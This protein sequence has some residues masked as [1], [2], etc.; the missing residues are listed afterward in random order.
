MSRA[1]APRLAIPAALFASCA[2]FAQTASHKP[3]TVWTDGYESPA[4][5]PRRDSDA[6]RFLAQATFGPT[7]A[8][9]ARLRTLGYRAWLDQQFNEPVSTSEPYLD[10]VG[11]IPDND[12]TDDTRLEIWAI[13]AA[14]LPD[15]SRGQQ[16]PTDL[17]R[18]RVAFALSQIFV[19]SNANGTLNY[20]PWAL[21]SYQDMLATRAFGNFSDLLKAVTLHPA[22]GIYLNMLQNQK[23]DDEQNIHPD[24]NF[25]REVL[26]LFSVGLVRLNED[27]TP[28][29]V[30]GQLVPTYNQA[31][32]R[33]F[34]AVFTG[35]NWSN[36]GC[37]ANTYTCCDEETYFWCGPGNR[38]EAPWQQPMQPVEAYHDT[39]TDKQLLNYATVS[40]P[41][42]VLPH[43]G[44]ATAELDAALANIVNHPNVGPFIARR[45]IQNLVTSNPSPAY[46]R[47][48]A[49]AFANN[50]QGV[51]GD[52]KA[53]LRAVLLDAEARSGHLQRPETFGKLREP[54]LKLTHMWRAMDARAGNGRVGNLSTWPPLELRLG[55]APL[56]SPTVF[57]FFKP[58]YS[59][60]GEVRTAGMRAPEFQILSDSLAVSTP[61]RLFYEL[62]CFY[63]GSDRCWD[64]DFADTLQMNLA[65]D[66]P[67][68]AS[69]PGALLDRYNLLFLSGQMSPFMRATILTQLQQ[70]TADDY[71]SALGRVRVQN[72]LY[73]ILN[74]PEYSVQK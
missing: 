47:R 15:P 26:Q 55:E 30:N 11:N 7:T 68:A 20:Q 49:A 12:V 9:I 71:G 56:R 25:A 22:M 36:V 27:G 37:G 57:N 39:T 65:R 18:Q 17:L 70:L 51:R 64:S 16:V 53:V 40:L 29:L 62:F 54:L 61:N 34:A 48:V 3:D 8:E 72:A 44:N 52:M 67:L 45:L 69:N 35:W 60:P 38:D 21:A 10:W 33:G 6:A 23:A 2:A 74:S 31:T 13:N 28:Q 43:G 5:G 24:E 41:G 19:V 50:G 63:T 59:P 66:A 1:A 46:V 14:A 32:V 58:D 42:G 4:D 73:L